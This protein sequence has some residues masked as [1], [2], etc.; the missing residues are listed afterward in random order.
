[1]VRVIRFLFVVLSSFYYRIHSKGLSSPSPLL[2]GDQSY[3]YESNS[4]FLISTNTD[5]ILL[6]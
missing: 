1:M 4:S 3:K 2:L 6:I 5:A